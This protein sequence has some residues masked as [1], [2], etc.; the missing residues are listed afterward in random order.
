MTLSTQSLRVPSTHGQPA[1]SIHSNWSGNTVQVSNYDPPSYCLDEPET[2]SIPIPSESI[3][4]SHLKICSF[5]SRFLPHT[6]SPIR[7]LLPLTG[8]RYMLI[9]H[10]NGLSV[11]D[12]FPTGDPDTSNPSDA[13]VRPIWEGEG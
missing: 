9:G 7:A 6:T 13:I 5:G 8:D 12:L 1:P 2:P 11:M 10:E 4:P 3:H